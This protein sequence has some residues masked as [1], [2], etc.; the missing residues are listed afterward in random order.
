MSIKLQDLIDNPKLL[1]KFKL[2]EH[3]CTKCG[4]AVDYATGRHRIG[5]G[6]VCD[7]CYFELLG[8]LIENQLVTLNRLKPVPVESEKITFSMT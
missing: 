7:D 1:D 4:C 5:I 8:E 2:P 3:K 6:N